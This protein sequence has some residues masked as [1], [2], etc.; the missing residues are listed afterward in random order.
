ML[1]AVQCRVLSCHSVAPMT[2]TWAR[3]AQGCHEA[4]HSPIH[5]PAK[6]A[7]AALPSAVPPERVREEGAE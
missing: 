7:V 3:P 6:M 5:G 4:E 2:H 1:R